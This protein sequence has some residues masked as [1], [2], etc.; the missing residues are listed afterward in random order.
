MSS[1][2]AMKQAQKQNFARFKNNFSSNS[3]NPF[4]K[5]ILKTNSNNP[6]KNKK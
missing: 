4:E 5:K 2:K 1:K 3:K 6:L